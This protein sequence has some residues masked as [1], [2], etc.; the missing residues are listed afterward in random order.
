MLLLIPDAVCFC[1]GIGTHKRGSIS[2][3]RF[4]GVSAAACFCGLRE[5]QRAELFM[6]MYNYQLSIFV[7]FFFL[8]VVGSSLLNLP[9]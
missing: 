3:V 8:E 9:T 7:Y 1:F 6:Y 4:E 2:N 5:A